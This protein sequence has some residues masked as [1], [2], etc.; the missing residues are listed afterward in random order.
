MHNFEHFHVQ[1]NPKNVHVFYTATLCMAK[2]DRAVPVI[3]GWVAGRGSRPYFGVNFVK[4]S[5]VPRARGTRRRKVRLP[6]GTSLLVMS[7]FAR[8][9]V[10]RVAR[11]FF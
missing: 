3:S 11:N 5:E 8:Q 4:K 6:L 9:K 7:G 10:S 1:R 2:L